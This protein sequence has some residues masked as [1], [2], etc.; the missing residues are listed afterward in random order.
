M[1]IWPFEGREE[2][3][4]LIRSRFI[5]GQVD[6][7]L[8][9]AAAGVG[10]TRLARQVISTLDGVAT[11][12]VGAT[13]AAASVPF[14]AVASLFPDDAP[15][16]AGPVELIRATVARLK[17]KGGRKRVVIVVDDAHLLDDASSTMI[18]D[19]V[20]RRV[21]FVIM[22]ARCGEPLADVLLR[23][24]KDSDAVRVD[25]TPLPDAVID[26]LIDHGQPDG[27]DPVRRRQLCQRA[28]G[29]PLALRELLQG[30]EPGGLTEL[31]MSR[32]D[33]LDPETRQAVELIACGEPLGVSLIDR[34]SGLGPLTRAEDAGL[35]VV[36]RHGERSHARL[37]HPLYGEALR[38]RMPLSR[39]IHLHRM[40]AEALLETPLRR[41]EDRLRAALWQVEGGAVTRPDVVRAGAWLAVG[42]A[43]LG[44]AERLARVAR[45]AEPGDEADRLLAEILA[46]RG[47]TAEAKRVLATHPPAV[48]DDR[49]AWA[50]TRAETLYWDGGDLAGAQSI[51]DTVRNNPVAEGSRSWILFFDGRCADA[52]RVA[53]RV[54]AERDAQPKAV[55]WAAAA[56]TAAAGFLGHLDEARRIHHRGIEVAK[57]NLDVLPWGAFEVDVGLCLAHLACGDPA[58]AQSIAQAGY[59]SALEGGAAMMLV[60]WAMYGGLAAAA[61][62]HLD[63]ARRLLN[64][65]AHG[66]EIN[67]TFR[68]SRSCHAALAAASGLCGDARAQGFMERA[69]ALAQPSNRI[70]DPWIEG[71]RAWTAYAAGDMPTAIAAAQRAADLAHDAGMPAVEALAIYD[72]ARLGARLDPS[73]LEAIDNDLAR[74]LARTARALS[75][76][77]GSRALEAA[78]RQL[79]ERGYDLHAAEAHAAAARQHRRHRRFAQADIAGSEGA[80]LRAPALGAS[81][82]LLRLGHLNSLLSPRE[83]QV[84]LMAARYTSAQI[85]DRLQ[86]A[87]STINNNLARAYAKLGITGRS[88]LRDLLG[89]DDGE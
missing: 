15:P 19:L 89:G 2:E 61:R 35:I 79:A 68:L 46:Y 36:E 6:A 37:D 71:W 43:D 50:V 48:P 40:L 16:D 84:L 60:G 45:A 66:F 73:R 25:L 65:A 33:D 55:V 87:V 26:R 57:A 7:L 31:V 13:R 59:D 10:K 86:L 11:A 17:A 8:I 23:L 51:Y 53:R 69:E 47:R 70:F 80:R 9:T 1:G 18:A 38:G 77:D 32:L 62:G 75:T 3:L 85:A 63:E 14:G 58:T 67:D 41:R 21:A 49:V 56:G 24:C 30:A 82:P 27:L 78:A 83:T 20:R 52:L 44:L 81:T 88:E 39:S 42:H 4:A 34:V 64:E 28:K 5:G 72:L 54:L 74:L 76:N 22:T 29:N 12:W